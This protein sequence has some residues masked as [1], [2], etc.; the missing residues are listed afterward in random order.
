MKVD[1]ADLRSQMVY[2]SVWTSAII[3]T[4]LKQRIFDSLGIPSFSKGAESCT[5]SKADEL[6]DK[7][8]TSPTGRELSIELF[9]CPAICEWSVEDRKPKQ[10]KMSNRFAWGKRHKQFLRAYAELCGKSELLLINTNSKTKIYRRPARD[11]AR[12]IRI[13]CRPM[14]P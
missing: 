6:R 7:E 2:A 12:P 8:S 14:A 13:L 11:H 10:Q 4:D 3:S 1:E 9:S 5:S